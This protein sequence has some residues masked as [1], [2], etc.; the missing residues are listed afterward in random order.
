MVSFSN[1]TLAEVE[2]AKTRRTFHH[3]VYVVRAARM[4]EERILNRIDSNRPFF[5]VSRLEFD[6]IWWKNKNTALVSI[7]K[8]RIALEIL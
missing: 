4:N 7:W 5:F 1:P 2:I 8:P 6:S 3:G